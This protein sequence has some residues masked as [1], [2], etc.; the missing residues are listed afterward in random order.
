M[1]FATRKRL[2]GAL[3]LPATIPNAGADLKV[4]PTICLPTELRI[5]YIMS[6]YV[7]IQYTPDRYTP[8]RD[9]LSTFEFAASLHASH[10]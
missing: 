4:L 9:L 7:D 5:M 1:S 6:T 3:V 8:N 10:V 2:Q